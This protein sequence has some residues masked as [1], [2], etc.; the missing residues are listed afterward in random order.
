MS[1]VHLHSHTHYS[2]LDGAAKIEDMV[3]RAA[4][5]KMPGLAITDHGNLFGSVEFYKTCKKH[6]VKPIIGMEAYMAPAERGLR[7]KIEGEKDSY[8][9]VILAKNATGF[10]NLIKLSSTAFLEGMYYKPRIDFEVLKKY[11]EGLIVTSACMSGQIAHKLRTDR[12]SEAIAHAEKYIELFGD[13]FYF[14][15]Q[16]HGIPD[17]QAVYPK[18][19]DLAREMGVKVVATND[20]HY[21]N[22]GDHRAHDVLICL[23][24]GKDRDDPN[25]MKY[26][27]EHLY[28]KSPDEM[29]SIFKDKSHVLENSMEIFEKIDLELDFDQRLLPKFPIPESEGVKSENEY[30]RKLTE[31][32]ARRHYPDMGKE[33]VER[34]NFELDVIEKMGFAGY[35]LIV[36]D[37]INAARKM[38][39]P[40]GLGRGSAA[41]SLVAYNLGITDVDP[42]RYDL[43]FE[44]FLNPERISMPDIDVDFCVERRDDVLEYVREKYGRRNVAQ[45]ITFG[46][47]GSKSVVR[48]VSRVLKVPLQQADVIAKLI[49]VEGA[50]PISL[51]RAFAEVPELKEIAQ[52]DDPVMRELVEYSQTLEG[53]AR[54][55]ST[56]AAGVI[57]APSDITDY[58]PLCKSSHGDIVTQWTMSYCEEMGLLKMDFLGLR[59][60]TVIHKTEKMIRERHKID[61]SVRDIP[62]D[63]A[64]TFRLYGEALTVGIFQFESTGMQEYIKKLKP[65]R[66]EDLIA[67]NALYRPGP[68][69]LIDDFIDRKYGRKEIKYL[70]PLLEPILKETYGIMVYQEQ[71]MRIV[72]DL[73]G[74]TLAEAD[75]MR[76]AMGKKK[77]DVMREQKDKFVKGCEG[78]NI[79]KKVATEIFD[80]IEKFARYGFNKSHSAAYAI[81]S[82]QTAYLKAHYPAEFMSANLTSEINKMDR[83]KFLISECKRIGLTVKPPDINYSHAHFRPL[84][85]KNIAFGMAAIKNVGENA[86]NNI[87]REREANG[88]YSSLFDLTKRVDLRQVN[89]K[90]LEAL[91][92]AGALDSLK[93]SRAQKYNA[94]ENA[95]EFGQS[96]QARILQN[97]DQISLFG[98]DGEEDILEISEPPL[99]DVPDWDMGERLKK[100]L[101]M[102]GFYVSGHPLDPYKPIVELYGT[103][104]GAL[105][106]KKEENKPLNGAEKK[107]LYICGQISEYRTQYDKKNN[108][109]AFIGLKSYDADFSGVIFG[110]VFAQCEPHLKNGAIVFVKAFLNGD[111]T[112]GVIRIRVESVYSPGQIPEQFT[113]SLRLTIDQSR[114]SE[115]MLMK[116][117]MTLESIPGRQKVFWNFRFNGQGDFAMRSVRAGIKLTLPALG[118]LCELVSCEN[119][120]IKMIE[121]G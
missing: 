85:D 97:K 49:P 106:R 115:D 70:H 109:M 28:M 62:M 10:R 71:V 39:I 11:S 66:I 54:H 93:G 95:I 88:P 59:N 110:S 86:I 34:M 2:L 89:K 40:V 27:T 118:Q 107:P 68:M 8:H 72:S 58:A 99:P 45:I 35:F 67:M 7:Q 30:L 83:V 23:Q 5:L 79:D 63:D 78:N 81:I 94:V 77:A 18:V 65:S 64:E 12:K 104:V 74:F 111:I 117:K 13:D 4:E 47:M 17:E 116:L 73:G 113:E 108:K 50:S 44:R 36:Q 26:G 46:T 105:I 37:F 103:D 51:K 98:G 91:A 29:F 14:E 84:D 25:R 22:H 42:L 119:I 90:V 60:L 76:R 100:E 102:I 114:M 55:N 38:D 15:I 112:D 43:L 9:L 21:L 56:H 19:Y 121:R 6:N 41:G 80:L 32:G 52:S 24:T 1:F 31:E 120:A 92:Q 61:F 16:D 96:V 57:I 3:L 53:I 48:D 87:V 69:D 33:V 75:M 101:E 20:T 82:Y